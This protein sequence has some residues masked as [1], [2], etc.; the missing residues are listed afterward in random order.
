M[1]SLLLVLRLLLAGLLYAFLGAVLLMLWRDL[2]GTTTQRSTSR[3]GGRLVI[4]ETIP[5]KPGDAVAERSFPLQPVTSIGRS[6]SNTVVV[7]DTYASSQHALLS[8]REG[9]WWLEDRDSRNGTFLNGQS[10]DQPTLVTGGDI[11]RIGETKLRLHIGEAS[12]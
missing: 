3:P 11:I 8:W 6:P 12:L 4:L 7:P 2:R 10:I 1:D 9:H 5:R